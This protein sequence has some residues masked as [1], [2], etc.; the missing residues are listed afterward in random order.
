L[1]T[2]LFEDTI[3]N[4]AYY[5]YV[6]GLPL[7]ELNKWE[8]ELLSMLDFDLYIPLSLFE[9]Y[10]APFESF[11]QWLQHSHIETHSEHTNNGR[12]RGNAKHIRRVKSVVDSQLFV[13]SNPERVRRQYSRSLS[14]LS[15]N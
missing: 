13:T 6:G 3:Y 11:V 14:A 10:S 15:L 8:L 12:A 2:K 4:N 5:S 1:A 7:K 9:S